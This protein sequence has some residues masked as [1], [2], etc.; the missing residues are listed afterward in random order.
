MEVLSDISEITPKRHVA[1]WEWVKA[2]CDTDVISE[3]GAAL[4]QRLTATPHCCGERRHTS[5]SASFILA[6]AAS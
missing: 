6:F 2:A 5:S 1:L 3:M 4:E